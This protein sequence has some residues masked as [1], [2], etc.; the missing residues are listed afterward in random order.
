M[1]FGG[2]SNFSGKELGWRYVCG[3][4]LALL[5]CDCVFRI[6]PF[7]LPEYISLV[8]LVRNQAGVGRH[9]SCFSS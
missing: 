1:A 8:A 4:T 3:V 7:L 2:V 5:R 6:F 9:P